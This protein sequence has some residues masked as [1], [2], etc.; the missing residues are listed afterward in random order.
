MFFQ[1]RSDHVAL[2][3]EDL[4]FGPEGPT[5]NTRTSHASYLY[6]LKLADGG[7]KCR[8]LLGVIGGTVQRGLS[9]A[10][11]LACDTDSSTIQ[12]LLRRSHTSESDSELSGTDAA[13]QRA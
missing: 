7:A 3:L 6:R 10:K 4:Y 12:G 9:D 8:A 1:Q 2:R 5:S 13:S 11:R